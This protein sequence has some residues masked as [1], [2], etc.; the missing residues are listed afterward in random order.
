MPDNSTSRPWW[1][2]LIKKETPMESPFNGSPDHENSATLE[3]LNRVIKAG[4]NPPPEKN[5][6]PF[7]E[8]QTKLIGGR[9]FTVVSSGLS[10]E[11]VGSVVDEL[12]Q[13]NEEL[14]KQIT[15]PPMTGYIERLMEELARMEE[16]IKQEAKRDAESEANNIYVE[17]RRNAQEIILSARREASELASQEAQGILSEAKKRAEIVEGQ[18]RVQAQLLLAK[19]RNQV[20]DHIKKESNAAYNRVLSALNA[21][22]IEAE[23]AESEWKQRTTQLWS[24]S[25]IKLALGEVEF[26]TS[27]IIQEALGVATQDDQPNVVQ[28]HSSLELEPTKSEVSPIEPKEPKS[29]DP[30]KVY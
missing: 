1:K 26:S 25:E 27:S 10:A 20:E 30:D 9:E 19:A 21:M 4:R 11:E 23:K 28:T 17:A 2:R 24:G 14:E 12:V 3:R 15:T 6:P 18:I 7:E 16:N 8:P 5:I 29:I 13:R 22:M